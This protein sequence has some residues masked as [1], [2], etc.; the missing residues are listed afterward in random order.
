MIK[1]ELKE[2]I[3]ALNDIESLKFTINGLQTLIKVNGSLL[4]KTN[5][6][7]LRIEEKVKELE[8]KINLKP[9]KAKQTTFVIKDTNER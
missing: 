9:K 7:L 2:E 8:I 5:Q 3:Q 6:K 4:A 1:I